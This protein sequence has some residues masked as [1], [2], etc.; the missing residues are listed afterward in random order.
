ME[1]AY[2]DGRSNDGY[3]GG[4]TCITT[5]RIW[6][7]GVVLLEYTECQLESCDTLS[8]LYIHW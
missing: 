3:I 6:M 5:E 8:I 1:I 2:T 4:I 7:T